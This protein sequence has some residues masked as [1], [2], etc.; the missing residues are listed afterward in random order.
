MSHRDSLRVSDI[1]I[2]VVQSELNFG[3]FHLQVDQCDVKGS[4]SPY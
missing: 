4:K 3:D 2:R 1:Q